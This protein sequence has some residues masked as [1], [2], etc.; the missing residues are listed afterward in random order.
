ML[1]FVCL[2]VFAF[3]SAT[4]FHIAYLTPTLCFYQTLHF[5]H[6][7]H[8]DDLVL[9]LDTTFHLL[10]TDIAFLP[11]T[12]FH[13]VCTDIAF[14]P[15]SIIISFILEGCCIFTKCISFTSRRYAYCVSAKYYI[16]P[17]WNGYCA[18]TKYH[19]SFTSHGYFVSDRYF[20]SVSC[21]DTV[22]SPNTAG[23][24]SVGTY[25]ETRSHATRQGTFGRSRLS[26]LSHCGLILA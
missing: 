26:S 15:N 3:L 19:L 7:T 14:P 9:S 25:P 2:F 17:T 4:T 6:L 8:V 12:I 5:V 23:G 21:I 16:L 11:S 1:L 22:L 10:Y 18:F 13:S 20:L 24:Q